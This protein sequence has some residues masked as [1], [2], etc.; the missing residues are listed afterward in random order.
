MPIAYSQ[1]LGANTYTSRLTAFLRA[2]EDSIPRPYV[3]TVGVPTIGWG[4]ALND[5]NGIPQGRTHVIQDVLGV[6]PNRPGLSPEARARETAY[7]GQLITALNQARAGDNTTTQ[8]GASSNALRADLN[9]ILAARA[10]DIAANY[11]QADRDLIGAPSTVFEYANVDQMEA[12][13]LRMKPEYDRRLRLGLQSNPPE[14]NERIALFTVAFHGSLHPRSA[15]TISLRNALAMADPN[16]AR[17]QA[18]YVLRYTRAAAFAR[19]S[20]L[21]SG[22]FGLYDVQEPMSEAVARGVYRMY[23]RNADRMVQWDAGTANRV[24]LADA[25]RVLAGLAIPGAS[26]AALEPSLQPAANQL[27]AQFGQGRAFSALN[28]RVAAAAGSTITGHATAADLM[29]GDAG[30]DKLVGRGGA[31]V[32]IGFGGNDTYVVDGADLI[33]D[34]GGRVED[35]NGQLIAGLWADRGDGVYRWV[36]TPAASATTNSPLTVTLTDGS[37]FTV[38]NFVNGDFGIRLVN[39]ATPIDPVTTRPINGDL[40]PQDFDAAAG[41]QTRTDEL[42]NVIVTAAAEPDRVDTLYG[43]A[44]ADRIIAGGGNDIISTARGGSD[45]IDAGAG[46]DFAAGGDGDDRIQ[47]GVGSDYLKG[48]AGKDLIESGADSDVVLGGAGDDRLYANAYTTLA[49]AW[50]QSEASGTGLISGLTNGGEG[51]DILVGVAGDDVL[52]GGGGADVIVA[53]AGGDTVWGD[54]D[55]T[56]LN[57][58]WQLLIQPETALYADIPML[59]QVQRRGVQ[60]LSEFDATPASSGDDVIYLGGG[61]DWTMTGPGDDLVFAD[62]GNDFAL[63]ELGDDTLI[64]GVG[65]DWLGGDAQYLAV[66]GL[67]GADFLDG[68]L[69]NDVLVGEAGSDTLFGG[70][71]NDFLAGDADASIPLFAQ[72][73]DILNGDGGADTLLGGGGDDIL[74][75]G[76]DNDTLKGGAGDDVYVFNAGDGADVIVDKEGAANVIRFGDTVLETAITARQDGAD[77]LLITYGALDSI[78]VESGLTAALA[79]IEVAGVAHDLQTFLTRFATT[80]V[81]LNADTLTNLPAGAFEIHGGGFGDTL[82]AGSKDAFKLVGGGGADTLTVTT[83]VASTTHVEFGSGD[84]ADR[85]RGVGIKQFHFDDGVDPLSVTA[86]RIGATDPNRVTAR[87]IVLTYAAVPPYSVDV[88][89]TIAVEDTANSINTRYSFADGSSLSHVELLERSN[90]ELDWLGGAGDEFVS[91]TILN[92]R[93]VGGGGGDNLEGRDGNDTLD[94]GAGFDTLRGEAGNDSLIG[95]A[96]R[97]TL[98]G[99]VGNDSLI[100]GTGN[101]VLD[102]GAGNDIYSFVAGDGIDVVIDNAGDTVVEFGT[103]VAFANVTAELINGTDGNIY[104]AVRSSPTDLVLVRQ[105]FGLAAADG[106]VSFKVAGVSYTGED[107][108]S[109]KLP[110]ALNFRGEHSSVRVTGSRFDDTIIGSTRD[111]R[112]EGGAGNDRLAGDAGRDTLIGGAGTDLL[113]GNAGDDTLDGGAGADTYRM[114]RGMGKDLVIEQGTDLNVLLL[115]AGLTT[116]DLARERSGDDLYL[117]LRN[118]RDGVH[119]RNYFV[120]G[121]TT[122]AQNWQVTLS[123]GTGTALQSLVGTL[124][125]TVVPAGVAALIADFKVRAQT[126]YEAALV[127][128][129]YIRQS[130]GRYVRDFSTSRDTYSSRTITTVGIALP[131]QVGDATSMTRDTEGLQRLSRTW[132]PTQTS[133][134]FQEL[135]TNGGTRVSFGGGGNRPSLGGNSGSNSYFDWNTYNGRQYDGI[136]IPTVGDTTPW[137][138]ITGFP[139]PD[140][141]GYYT[142]PTPPTYTTRTVTRFHDHVV[143]EYRLNILDMTAGASNNV[144][145]AS[146][147]AT[148]DGGA[149]DDQITATIGFQANYVYVPEVAMNRAGEPGVLLYGNA[150]NDYLTGSS[151]DDVLIGGAGIDTMSGGGGN[152][153]Y[154]V[155][156]GSGIDEIIEDG[157]TDPGI[158]GEDVLRLPTG[159]TR[160]ALR[161]AWTQELRGEHFHGFTPSPF[162][163]LY[164]VLTVTWGTSDGAKLVIPHV[165]AGVGTG[166]D[167]I[168]FADGSRMSFS[169]ILAIA[170]AE[171]NPHH[172]ANTLSGPGIIAGG[173]GNDTVTAQIAIGNAGRDTLIGTAGD[174]ELYG[175]DQLAQILV[176]SPSIGTLWDEGSTFRPGKGN[177]YMWATAGSDT[178]EFAALDGMDTVIDLQ[179]DSLHWYYGGSLTH[180]VGELDIEAVDPGHRA[181]LLANTDTL[182]FGTGIIPDDIEVV[183]MTAPSHGDGPFDYLVFRHKNGADSVRFANWFFPEI[184]NQLSR[185]TFIGGEVWDSSKIAVLAT[186]AKRLERGSDSDD[187][188][189]G[190][191]LDE[192]LRGAGGADF[193][194]GGQGNDVLDGGAGND[195]YF[196]SPGDG[197]DTISDSGLNTIDVLEFGAGVTSQSLT[198]GLGSLLI[199]VG[200]G[201]DAIHVEGFDPNNALGSTPIDSVRFADGS[202][203]TYAQLL[204]RGFDL[205]GTS[206][207]ET[208]TGTN[209]TDRINGFEGTDVLL[210]GAGDDTYAFGSGSG[211]DRIEDSAGTLDTVKLAA[212][213]T[214]GQVTVTRAGN[215]LTLAFAG[216]SDKLTIRQETGAF[217]IER[218]LFA[219]GSSWDAATLESKVPVTNTAP[220]V[221]SAIPDLAANEDALLSYVVPATTFSDPGDTLTYSATLSTGAALP[222][223]LAFNAT[224]RTFSGTPLNANVGAIDVNVRATDTGALS[225]T[226][227]FRITVA[228]VN[229]APVVAAAI[230]DLTANEDAAFSYVVPAATFTDVDV[231][232]TLAYAAT[233]STGAALPSWLTFT[234]ATRTF[235]GTPLNANVGAIDVSVRATDNVGASVTDTFRVTVANVNDAPVLSTLIPDLTTNEDA[236]F[237][238]VVPAGTFTDIDPGATLTYAATLSTGAALPSWLTFTA[239]TRTFS[240]TP[241]NANVG[242]LDLNVR[243]TDV[244]GASATDTFRITVANVNDAPAVAAAVPDQT[245]TEDVAFSYVV[246]AATFTDVDVGAT[247]TYSATLSTGAALPAWLTF[248]AATRTFSGTPLNANVGAID[249]NVRATDD[250]G[251]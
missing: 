30:A 248:A 15:F 60:L 176:S 225:A 123:N 85:V 125:T 32:M 13:F 52:M 127:T 108:A 166:I 57:I 173:P 207:D 48:D 3:D 17:A 227:T 196:F 118:S 142:Y 216:I 12:T 37:T 143:E 5:R 174:D 58:G 224:T 29:L 87:D 186:G 50:A 40:A 165:E 117:H 210:G 91:A 89:D 171:L 199:R 14:T 128:G 194:E 49:D 64:G 157:A 115:D 116:A 167:L 229:D 86:T 83:N 190:S 10:V 16:D 160:A 238:Y 46:Q 18:W 249:V 203:L 135:N 236:A 101:D 100:G 185:V 94:G 65:N 164:A 220:V 169:E 6:N 226:D 187:F 202:T 44:D 23:S 193:L 53:G 213:I 132:T 139:I 134:T 97:D 217:R 92:D 21:E 149:G 152:D 168:E 98:E 82:S 1:T 106:A 27:I 129:G 242:A 79:S 163:S 81:V 31:D 88:L 26:A 33:I 55:A 184:H 209:L 246:P 146:E 7:R 133:H 198:L 182:A 183:R 244:A 19:R 80:G 161:F 25:G 212:G 72:G 158:A 62:S 74:V 235:S 240:G 241:L 233:L 122:N 109:Q 36:Q 54:L 42:G 230:P 151:S 111:D 232:A 119:I 177:D 51:D 144:I 222:T 39:D 136:I 231:G 138:P 61:D 70:D 172:L 137:D 8:T 34:D 28:V 251:A 105:S 234:A 162:K 178:F 195:T 211:N 148:I 43:S 247:L 96:D 155:L 24:V 221:A 103:G 71:G 237:N 90:L 200:Q 204:A 215:M 41:V 154:V 191:V 67:G 45:W 214:Q 239:A 218:V 223:W 78:S 75:G 66:A 93:L 205:N 245:A 47:G 228:N 102:G 73:A 192:I 113:I 188:I 76:R 189:T 9:A 77:R 63:G 141:T 208:L 153:V 120:P 181:T 145:S 22:M 68:G 206:G 175:G 2:A 112:L 84:G 156:A 147:Y 56:P 124:P 201:G 35:R 59:P 38:Q 179:H 170:P 121:S 95:G 140:D 130:D 69:G 4:F 131:T 243:A 159:V 197:V 20:Y 110:Q 114:H 104:L 107:F 219:D 150:G 11:A 99:G 126:F 250:V 180:L